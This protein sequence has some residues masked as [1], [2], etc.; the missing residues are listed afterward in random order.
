MPSA[1][2]ATL[3]RE[4][5]ALV[6][7]GALDRAAAAALWPQVQA[8]P[9]DVQ[10]IVLTSVTTVDSAGLALLAELAARLRAA[11]ASVAIEGEPAGLADLRAAYRLTPDLDY[12][13]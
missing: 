1:T 12:P 13:A 5:G 2:D 7:A 6:F 3:R 9:T 4:D 10:R 8:A 11:G